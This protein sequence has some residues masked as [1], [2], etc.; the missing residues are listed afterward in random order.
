M[1]PP[2][3]FALYCLCVVAAYTLARTEGWILFGTGMP[4]RGSNTGSHTG[5]TGGH[6]GIYL[7]SHK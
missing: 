2:W 6:S 7:G 3:I 5:G 4:D 1:R